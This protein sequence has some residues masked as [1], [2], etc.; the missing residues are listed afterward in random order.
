MTGVGWHGC[1]HHQTNKLLGSIFFLQISKIYFSASLYNDICLRWDGRHQIVDAFLS[2]AP[3]GVIMEVQRQI[4][5]VAV[6]I[7]CRTLE[8]PI[9]IACRLHSNWR[10][11][12]CQIWPTCYKAK[13]MCCNSEWRSFQSNLKGWYD[14]DKLKSCNKNFQITGFPK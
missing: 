10:R 3:H 6:V 13:K 12:F 9:Q 14:F 5:S 1:L 4:G 2:F 8:K 11:A 7:K